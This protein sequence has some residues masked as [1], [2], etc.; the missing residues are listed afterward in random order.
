MK[1]MCCL[2]AVVTAACVFSLHASAESAVQSNA[3]IVTST[4]LTEDST[5][6]PASVTILT[7]ED[8]LRRPAQTLPELL[9]LEAGVSM[10]SLYGNHAARATV[11]MR[12]FGAAST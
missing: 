2:I 5:R 11:D 4:R 6:L 12:G 7:A 1:S 9:A 10:R 8:I 3:V